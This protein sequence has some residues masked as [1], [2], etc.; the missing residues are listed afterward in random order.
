MICGGYLE[1]YDLVRN[2]CSFD[3]KLCMKLGFKS[4]AKAP[5][6][7]SIIDA[8]AGRS[9]KGER[10][11]IYGS[12]KRLIGAVKQGAAAVWIKDYLLDKQLLDVVYDNTI[13]LVFPISD[14]V[15]ANGLQRPRLMSKMSRLLKYSA[16][17]GIGI[18]FITMAESRSGMC[19]YMQI[20]EIAKL[21]GADEECARAGLSEINKRMLYD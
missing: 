12:G 17:L 3:E 1:Y 7:I 15:C 6:D 10:S 20:V 13:P 2:S 19:S 16:K 18:S 8:D 4:I 11:I 5:G 9:G 14:I 21:L